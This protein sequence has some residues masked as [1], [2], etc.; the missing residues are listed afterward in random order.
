MRRSGPGLERGDGSVSVDMDGI[1]RLFAGHM[2]S[3]SSSLRTAKR[4]AE[5]LCYLPALPLLLLMLLLSLLHR[6]LVC[7]PFMMLLLFLFLF[8]ILVKNERATP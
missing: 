1:I 7:C 3:L 6:H 8:L 2:F 5:L 4:S